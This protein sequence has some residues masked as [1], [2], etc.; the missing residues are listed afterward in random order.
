MT[1]TNAAEDTNKQQS[2]DF[3]EYVGYV[4]RKHSVCTKS[5][6]PQPVIKDVKVFSS[7]DAQE[8]AINLLKNT[9]YK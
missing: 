7:F 8:T 6:P 5:Q 4:M 1:D 9:I 2:F 3:E